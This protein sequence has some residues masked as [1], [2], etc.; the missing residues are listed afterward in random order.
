MARRIRSLILIVLTFALGACGEVE[1]GPGTLLP[2]TTA[3]FVAPPNPISPTATPLSPVMSQTLEDVTVSVQPLY[4]DAQRV[5]LTLSLER[6]AQSYANSLELGWKD[7]MESGAPTL[8]SGGTEL[9]WLPQATMGLLP[10]Y[11]DE[12]TSKRGKITFS[13]SALK[14]DGKDVPLH[15]TLPLRVNNQPSMFPLPM[16]TDVPDV[17]VATEMPT[18]SYVL[19]FSFSF[20]MPFDPRYIAL[21]TNQ[22]VRS[23]DVPMTLDSIDITAAEIRVR[24]HYSATKPDGFPS[25]D[26]WDAYGILVIGSGSSRSEAALVDAECG[27]NFGGNDCL[28]VYYEPSLL[29]KAPIDC[30]LTIEAS[31]TAAR[32]P[33]IYG[34]WVFQFTVPAASYK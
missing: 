20:T 10:A 27:T 17:P 15:L 23:N 24:L 8:V 25:K 34:T 32:R 11:P 12:P 9:P 3:T 26:Y 31:D 33:T 14:G 16:P 19:T 1:P 13:A 5:V 28:L 4:A 7:G 29:D 2:T 18:P 21:Q 30:T 6:P 22:T